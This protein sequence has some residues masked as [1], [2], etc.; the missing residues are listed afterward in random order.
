MIPA[1]KLEKAIKRGEVDEGL[2]DDFFKAVVAYGPTIFLIGGT[3]S[4][5]AV[6]TPLFIP[7]RPSILSEFL[8]AQYLF[9]ISKSPTPVPT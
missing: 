8:Y 6:S 3:S 1:K 2:L 5:F 9:P 7:G 4:L